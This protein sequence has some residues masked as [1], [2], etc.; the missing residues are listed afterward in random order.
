MYY[1]LVS[2][3]AFALTL[4]LTPAA[5]WLG[6]QLDLVDRPGGRRHHQGVIPRT[7]GI[8]IFGG[9]LLTLLLTLCTAR[10]PA[11]I[12]DTLVAPAQ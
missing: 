8:A 2:F 6:R 9:F 5:G 3:C 1:W 11:C 12:H 7:G 10:T 4:L